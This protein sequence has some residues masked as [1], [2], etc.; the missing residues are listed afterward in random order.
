MAGVVS[1]V[2]LGHGLSTLRSHLPTP[3]STMTRGGLFRATPLA[4]IRWRHFG[5]ALSTRPSSATLTVLP[6][7]LP[8]SPPRRP[9]FCPSLRSFH[10]TY[11]SSAAAAAR[12]TTA[13]I[14]MK[15]QLAVLRL[16]LPSRRDEAGCEFVMLPS[17]STVDQL[18]AEIQKEDAGIERIF[19]T[20]R[21][22]NRIESNSPYF[23]GL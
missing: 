21:L 11:S 16:P 14:S 3:A 20:V 12:L 23:R 7:F 13:S 6:G 15:R 9:V 18:V 5:A 10:T 4:D 17:S 22:T 2:A 8:P 19:V 1:K